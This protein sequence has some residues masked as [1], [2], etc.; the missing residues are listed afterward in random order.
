M[1]RITINGSMADVWRELT[2]NDRP[3]PCFFNMRMDVSD[4]R[5]GG[6]LRM[7]TRNGKYTGVV[8]EILEWN[9][10]TSFAHTFRFTNFND[11]PCLVRFELAGRDGAVELTLTIEDLPLG[12]K[13]AK[14]MIQGS[15]LILGTLKATVEGRPIPFMMRFI[16]LMGTGFAPFTPKACLSSRWP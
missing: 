3:L 5:P 7:R 6:S 13:T 16:H 11:P 1:F 15:E 14:Q 10:P 8:G 4:H 9:P 2:R 12:T